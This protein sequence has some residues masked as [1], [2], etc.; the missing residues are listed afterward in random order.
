MTLEEDWELLREGVHS[1]DE[2]A[3]HVPEDIPEDIPVCQNATSIRTDPF[4]EHYR[5]YLRDP[6]GYFLRRDAEDEAELRAEERLRQAEERQ[7]RA[8][9]RAVI[10]TFLLILVLVVSVRSLVFHIIQ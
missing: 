10:L 2:K 8:V 1:P 7:R 9:A 5:E 6:E 4:V 3:H